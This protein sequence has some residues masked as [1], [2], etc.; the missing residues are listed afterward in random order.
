MF[1]LMIEPDCTLEQVEPDMFQ[2]VTIA[3]GSGSPR[4]LW[5]NEIL[6]AL[7]RAF[8]K[9]GK[10]VAAICLSPVVL[11]EA[12]LLKGLEATVYKSPKAIGRMQELGAIVID[13]E[14]VQVGR[15]LT[16]RDPQAAEAYGQALA[17]I[18]RSE[19]VMQAKD[20]R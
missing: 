8:H 18:L 12:G 20:S 11:A 1:G 14:T 7:V 13:S 17:R 2:A 6:Q 10:I 3:G 15:I 5:K 16:G 9:G 4:Y 19:L